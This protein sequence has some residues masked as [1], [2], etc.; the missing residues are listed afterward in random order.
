MVLVSKFLNP[1]EFKKSF[2]YVYDKFYSANVEVSDYYRDKAYHYMQRELITAYLKSDSGTYFRTEA[3]LETLDA[4]LMNSLHGCVFTLEWNENRINFEPTSKWGNKVVNG[5]H[6]SFL[7]SV[8][9]GISVGDDV[10]VPII[11]NNM[12]RHNLSKRKNHYH[13]FIDKTEK[14][15]KQSLTLNHKLNFMDFFEL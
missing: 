11:L 1:S 10:P 6:R 7:G 4:K 3:L 2:Q 13:G 12:E 15:M 9:Y 8:S 14:Y 5:T